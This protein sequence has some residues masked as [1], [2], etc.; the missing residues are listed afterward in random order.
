MYYVRRLSNIPNLEKIK[1]ANNIEDI[2]SDILRQELGT[3]G[4]TLS[5]WKCSNLEDIN[6]TI[7]AI[8]LSMSEIK[9]SQFY[10]I[11]DGIIEKYGLKM[12]DTQPGNT[13]YKGFESLHSDMVELTYSKIGAV[14]RML[15]EIF[16]NP[17]NTKKV[18]RQKVKDYILEVIKDDLL[19]EDALNSELKEDIEKY[20]TK[21]N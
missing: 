3:T 19:N 14:L 7:K 10:I 17:A 11:N 9:K 4:N 8:L 18:D 21:K 2:D 16:K 13:G 12:D 15:N 6:D 5:F 20:F 1:A